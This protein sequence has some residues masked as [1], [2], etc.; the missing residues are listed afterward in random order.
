MYIIIM[1]MATMLMA[2]DCSVPS[3]SR[4]RKC[5]GLGEAWHQSA[6]ALA[7]PTGA[8]QDEICMAPGGWN[9]CCRGTSR[10]P[11]IPRDY[12]ASYC[13]SWVYGYWLEIVPQLRRVS[14]LDS[15]G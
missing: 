14:E 1:I 12:H 7:W 13:C 9:I 3:F 2:M 15:A 4:P 11:L 10:K 5:Y 6:E 8:S